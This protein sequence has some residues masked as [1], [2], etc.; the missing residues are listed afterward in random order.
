MFVL[1]DNQ[2]MMGLLYESGAILDGVH[3]GVY[4]MHV[5]LPESADQLDTTAAPRVLKVAASGRLRGEAR[6]G[7]L[8]TRF[9]VDQ[10]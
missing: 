3:E 9:T 4:Q 6:P 2:S 10:G 7:L 8:G 5:E 1:G